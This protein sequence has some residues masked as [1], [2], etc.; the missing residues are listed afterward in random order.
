M[1]LNFEIFEGK[2]L[3]GLFKDIYLNQQRTS[4]QIDIL[5]TEI[6]QQC[7]SLS[8]AIIVVPMIKSY[9]D[10]GV[11]NDEQLIK[12]AAIVQRLSIASETNGGGFEMTED[13]RQQLLD[14]AKE[15]GLDLKKSDLESKKLDKTDKK[16]E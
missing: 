3:S 11:R 15:I 6:R 13:E 2:N 8:D 7:K 12:L 14:S 16:S 10:V 1:D 4:E 5:I 9:L